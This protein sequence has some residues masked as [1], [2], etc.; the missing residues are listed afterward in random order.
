[1]DATTPDTEDTRTLNDPVVKAL[2]TL[3]DVKIVKIPKTPKDVKVPD[4]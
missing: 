4:A 3:I 1:M 2:N